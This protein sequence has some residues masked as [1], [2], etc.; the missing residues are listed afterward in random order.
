MFRRALMAVAVVA[1]AACV[2]DPKSSAGFRLPNGDP[3]AGQEAF[4]S[5]ECHACHRVAGLDL[6]EPV[7]DPP[8]PVIL[9]GEIPHIRTDGELLTSIINPSHEIVP[10]YRTEGVTRG[11][12][13]RM[14]D[15]SETMTVRQLIDIVAFLQSRYTVVRPGDESD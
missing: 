11:D 15:L 7:A 6:P 5:L 10:G 1:L 4:V 9:G 14:S 3:V 13:S 2:A 8:V 12:E